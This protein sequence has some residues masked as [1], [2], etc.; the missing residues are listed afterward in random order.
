MSD[1]VELNVLTSNLTNDT[2]SMSTSAGADMVVESELEVLAQTL[3]PYLLLHLPTINVGNSV[4][5]I[6]SNQNSPCSMQ[7]MIMTTPQIC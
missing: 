7:V 2:A 1:S 5:I 3:S 4:A 6:V